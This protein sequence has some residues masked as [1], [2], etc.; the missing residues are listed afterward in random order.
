MEQTVKIESPT[1]CVH[2]GLPNPYGIEHNHRTLCNHNNYNSDMGSGRY[3][4]WPAVNKKV[5]CKRCL[6][7]SEPEPTGIRFNIAWNPMVDG[8]VS[9]LVTRNT[10]YKE[11]FFLL[12]PCK[13]E[14]F[15]LYAGR[16]F[17]GMRDDEGIPKMSKETADWLSTIARARWS[18]LSGG[19]ETYHWERS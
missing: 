10:W 2:V 12:P 5:T 8:E 7:M 3:H 6:A 16:D 14:T 4:N 13:I 18:A 9:A 1:G 15:T 11:N 17:V 19:M